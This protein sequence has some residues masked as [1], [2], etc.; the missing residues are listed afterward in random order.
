MIHRVLK[1][2]R[3]VV[4][5]L[6]ATRK[7][8]A[9]GVLACLYE[10]GAT[11]RIMDRAEEVMDSA[12]LNT[13]FTY[14]NPDSYRAL[15]VIGPASSGSEFVDTLVHEIHHLAVAVADSVGVDLESETPAYLAGDSARALAD[16]ICEMGCSHNDWRKGII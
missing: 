9:E 3:W 13:G 2:G 8:D 5:F 10:L 4:D 7:Y 15:V 1:I 6:F 14:T 16:V 11:E 12:R